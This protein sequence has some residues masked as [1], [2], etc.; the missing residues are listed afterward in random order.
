MW[1]THYNCKVNE[2]Q[3][4]SLDLHCYKDNIG[5]GSYE[6]CHSLN[7]ES[8]KYH[9]VVTSPHTR[10]QSRQDSFS[11]DTASS[12]TYPPSTIHTHQHCPPHLG[13]KGV[14]TGRSNLAGG[15]WAFQG[16]LGLVQPKPNCTKFQP[17]DQLE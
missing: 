12:I 16:N 17:G 11:P 8:C 6:S 10:F 4:L 3:H 15:S 5:S 2:N 14:P 9:E 13:H 1:V 7:Q